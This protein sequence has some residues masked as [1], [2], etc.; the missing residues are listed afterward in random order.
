M[1]ALL[2]AA[3]VLFCAWKCVQG[4]C[5]RLL[6]WVLLQA[7][8]MKRA[9]DIREQLVGLM[10][11]VEIEM[12]SDYSNHDGEGCAALPL[13]GFVLRVLLLFWVRLSDAP[14]GRACGST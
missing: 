13:G 14:A 1:Y 5:P 11:R 10:E 2:G 12:V 3:R 6:C 9:R 4:S 7:R 8:S